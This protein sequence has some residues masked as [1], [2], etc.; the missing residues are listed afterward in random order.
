MFFRT[1]LHVTKSVEKTKN[2]FLW[3][4]NYIF[5]QINSRQTNAWAFFCT[6][7]ILYSFELNDS[8]ANT[9]L[10]H[11]CINYVTTISFILPVWE[12]VPFEQVIAKTTT[13]KRETERNLCSVMNLLLSS[14]ILRRSMPT[15]QAWFRGHINGDWLISVYKENKRD[16]GWSRSGF[17]LRERLSAFFVVVTVRWCNSR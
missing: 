13:G 15:H 17:R 8:H 12:N 6:Q 11:I 14:L 16:R 5:S 10:E 3:A 2:W 4:Y 1:A 7:Y 9:Q